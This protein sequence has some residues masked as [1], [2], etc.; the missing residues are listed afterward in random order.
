MRSTR[1]I[2]VEND[3]TL[4]S[5][6]TGLLADRP[7]IDI[8]LS[9][10][11]PDGALDNE[12]LQR[13]D[14]AL[15]DLALGADEMNGIDLGLAMREINENIGIVIHS[16][17]RLDSVARHVPP[18]ARI[19]WV[20]MPKTGSLTIDEIV[21]TLR[22]AAAGVS[23]VGDKVGL[24]RSPLKDMTIRQRA[25]MGMVSSGINTHEISRRLGIS[26]AAVRQ[27]LTRAYRILVPDVAETDEL[28]TRAILAYLELVRDDDIVDGF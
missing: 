20:T 25:V 8:I 4:R 1:V 14:A 5:I 19:G 6:M 10:G 23:G 22:G 15:I 28:R 27:D 11:T 18:G 16:Q 7:E 9:V 2:Y 12:S 24:N 17:Y 26:H 13:A 3:P 21:D